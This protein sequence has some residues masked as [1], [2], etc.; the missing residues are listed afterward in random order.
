[1][2]RSKKKQ[3]PKGPRKSTYPK[4]PVGILF[5]TSSR[6]NAKTKLKVFKTKNV[7]ELIDMDLIIPGIP[8]RAIILRV[9]IG[10]KLVEELK[11]KIN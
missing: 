10:E 3:V 4:A 1:M 8:E 5:K 9:V 11:A 6:S 2:K 7:D